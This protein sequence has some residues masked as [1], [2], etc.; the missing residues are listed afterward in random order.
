MHS[1]LVWKVK[2]CLAA[3]AAVTAGLQTHEGQPESKPQR[4]ISLAER[5][6]CERAHLWRTSCGPA[7]LTVAAVEFS[8]AQ[9]THPGDE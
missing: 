1:T 3:A 4:R 5:A 7:A 9:T 8:A 6:P 2:F